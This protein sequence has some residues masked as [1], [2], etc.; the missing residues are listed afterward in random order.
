MHGKRRSER[1]QHK[2]HT[3]GIC[4]CISTI[5]VQLLFRYQTFEQFDISVLVS[6]SGMKSK[7]NFIFTCSYLKKNDKHSKVK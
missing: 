4:I 7:M 3:H 5:F 2:H 1:K 6:M